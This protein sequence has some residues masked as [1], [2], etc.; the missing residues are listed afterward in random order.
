MTQSLNRQNLSREDAINQVEIFDANGRL[1]PVAS[2]EAN[3]EVFSEANV[4]RVAPGVI[5]HA[6]TIQKHAAE[7]EFRGDSG[8]PCLGR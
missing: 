3:K 1:D 4:V 6:A 2:A 8:P 5:D 7:I